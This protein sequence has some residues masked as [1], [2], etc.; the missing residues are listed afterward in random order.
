MNTIKQ[1][2]GCNILA[3]LSSSD[4]LL[5]SVLLAIV[6]MIGNINIIYYSNSRK[7][8]TEHRFVDSSVDSLLFRFATLFGSVRFFDYRCSRELLY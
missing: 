1:K 7:H 4:Y 3:S 6:K 2:C 8:N 5:N